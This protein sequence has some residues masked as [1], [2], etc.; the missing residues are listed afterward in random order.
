MKT[1]NTIA[2]LSLLVM[3]AAAC[4]G[5]GGSGGSGAG[6]A[7]ASRPSCA[8]TGTYCQSNTLYD[9]DTN[10]V[11][12]QCGSCQYIGPGTGSEYDTSCRDQESDC[13]T[14]NADDPWTGAGCYFGGG[15]AV[16]S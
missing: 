11:I 7:N 2:F 3:I 10:A 16:C 13:S 14:C 12:V 5:S 15:P 8:E 6:T 1:R 4:G 9:C